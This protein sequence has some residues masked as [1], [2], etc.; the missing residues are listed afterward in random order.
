MK[1]RKHPFWHLV[2]KQVR[3]QS[4]KSILARMIVLKFQEDSPL[5]L[6]TMTTDIS[7]NITAKFVWLHKK[8]CHDLTGVLA[9][10]YTLGQKCLTNNF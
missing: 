1:S 2:L 5:C 4:N 6:Q 9:D 7:H 10:M 8:K 3:L